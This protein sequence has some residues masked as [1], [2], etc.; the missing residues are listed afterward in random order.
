[1]TLLQHIKIKFP[2]AKTMGDIFLTKNKTPDQDVLCGLLFGLGTV[3]LLSPSETPEEFYNFILNN[4]NS[5]EVIS[6]KDL[7]E[8]L[9]DTLDSNNIRNKFNRKFLCVLRFD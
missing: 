3:G 2:N 6:L 8:R 5:K 9:D 7:E 1:M 4:P